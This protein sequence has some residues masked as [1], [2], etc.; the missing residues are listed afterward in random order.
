MFLKTKE[1]IVKKNV[2]NSTYVHCIEQEWIWPEF[3]LY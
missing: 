2:N 1:Y 3:K